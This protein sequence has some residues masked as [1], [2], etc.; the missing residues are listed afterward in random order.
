MRGDLSA[1]D[2]GQTIGLIELVYKIYEVTYER[3]AS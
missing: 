2:R 3:Q 1:L